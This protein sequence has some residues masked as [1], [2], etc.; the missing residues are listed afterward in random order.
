MNSLR[1]SDLQVFRPNGDSRWAYR[2]RVPQEIPGPRRPM[3]RG[4]P[5]R[6]DAR[7]AAQAR[8]DQILAQAHDAAVLPTMSELIA[9]YVMLRPG[10]GGGRDRVAWAL[11]KIN[12]A[13]G[14]QRID[15]LSAR[16]I[17]I[18]MASLDTASTRWEISRIFRQ[19]FAQ[20]ARHHNVANPVSVAPQ[21]RRAEVKPF[22]DPAELEKVAIELGEW[23]DAV[24]F[25][26]G[27]GLRPEE[28]IPLEGTD[29]DWHARTVTVRRTY[30]EG[31]GLEEF[32]GKTAGSIRT[33]PLSTAA[34]AALGRQLQGR[35]ESGLVFPAPRGGYL[36]LRN[37]RHRDW[38]PALEAGGVEPRGPNAL[39]H[40]FATWFLLE[41]D[42]R[43]LL[44]KLMGSSVDMIEAHY[45]HL[46][47][48]H[49]ERSRQIL[50]AIWDG[51][52]RKMDATLTAVDAPV[53]PIPL[54]QAQNTEAL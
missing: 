51:F 53:P 46:L 5:T 44:A 19:L 41:S 16:D 12:A 30:T 48:P 17:D 24:R 20:A 21:P 15:Q 49:A 26:A 10:K 43:W 18:W 45:G 22:K 54:N 50:D 36:N 40:T 39:R 9:D 29:V 47:A 31:K 11:A 42:D 6:R 25:V 32:A 13:F 52:G 8:I 3:G 33:V 35:A 2:F 28:W 7:Q 4:Y 23:G 14:P 1:I 34:L 38:H 27:T 37:W